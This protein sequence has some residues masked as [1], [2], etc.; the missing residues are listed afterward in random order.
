MRGGGALARRRGGGG[1]D[2]S[3]GAPG[4]VFA[5]ADDIQPVSI[6]VPSMVV[7]RIIDGEE[8]PREV[9][10]GL[11]RAAVAAGE[12]RIA[13]LRGIVA[14]RA[15]LEEVVQRLPADKRTFARALNRERAARA[16]AEERAAMA[17]HL[18]DSVLQTLT[19]LQKRATDPGAVVRFA[20][21]TERDLRAFLYGSVDGGGGDL[22]GALAR[23]LAAVEDRYDVTVD[24]VTAGTCPLD[25]RT[26]AVVGATREAV[27]NAARHAR[28]SRVAVFADVDGGE[29]LVRVRDRGCGFDGGVSAPDRHG[30]RNSIIGR[31]DR[32]GGRA[33]VES[34][35][36]EGTEVELRM[37]VGGAE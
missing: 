34:A 18:H 21:H 24:L 2:E 4:G 36:G 11:L 35:I 9:V 29:V 28:V 5:D 26:H 22:A 30:I 13:D 33:T 10:L 32:H 17:A 3:G 37:P 31:M 27:T 20:R 16:R 19:L 23:E 12:G 15:E 8:P 14:E 7:E 6:D 1:A 25:E